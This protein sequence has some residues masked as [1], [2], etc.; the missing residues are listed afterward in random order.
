MNRDEIKES[1]RKGIQSV[2][3]KHGVDLNTPEG[4]L[5]AACVLNEVGMESYQDWEDNGLRMERL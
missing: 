1:I 5:F 2:C 4:R 3:D